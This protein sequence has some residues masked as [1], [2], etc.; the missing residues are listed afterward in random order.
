MDA[1]ALPGYERNTG[2][3]RTLAGTCDSAEHC[4]IIK[5][6]RRPRYAGRK[7]VRV[8]K[9]SASISDHHHRMENIHEGDEVV[10][11]VARCLCGGTLSTPDPYQRHC[12]SKIC[13][14]PD[15]GCEQHRGNGNDLAEEEE[16]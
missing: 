13:S 16:V 8:E 11:L 9:V 6:C 10:S 5:S 2:L 3:Q 1:T 15:H 4:E 7:S 14:D 12:S